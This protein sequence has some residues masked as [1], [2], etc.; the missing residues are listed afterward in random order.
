[1]TQ[2][3]PD[4]LPPIRSKTE[5]IPDRLR[6][7]SFDD[8]RFVR[9]RGGVT[10]YLAMG[11]QT[12]DNDNIPTVEGIDYQYSSPLIDLVKASV[13][14]RARHSAKWHAKN[15]DTALYYELMLQRVFDDR[16][17]E[18]H[19]IIAGISTSEGRPYHIYGT[20]SDGKVPTEQKNTPRG[21]AGD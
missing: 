9:A 1:M 15:Q 4:E 3:Y 2:N 19:H 14:N 20:T 5:P 8:E 16:S 6:N 18:L 21:E 17:L 13:V 10:I 12:V 11:L 7:P